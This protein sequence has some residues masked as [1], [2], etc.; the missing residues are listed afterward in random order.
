VSASWHAY[1]PVVV[2]M[3]RF[4]ESAPGGVLFPHF[5]FTVEAVLSAVTKALSA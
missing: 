1:A 5:G 2:G 4:G 3:D